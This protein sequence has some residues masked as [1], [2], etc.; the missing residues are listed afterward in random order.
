ML[1]AC[2]LQHLFL[3]LG[4]TKVFEI[5][6]DRIDG[7]EEILDFANL[8]SLTKQLIVGFPSKR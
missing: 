7:T 2:Y 8:S 5:W 4:D 1:L 6:S 3:F